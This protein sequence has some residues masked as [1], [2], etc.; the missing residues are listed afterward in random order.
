MDTTPCPSMFDWP[1]RMK[2]FTGLLFAWPAHAGPAS[3][4]MTITENIALQVTVL[5]SNLMATSLGWG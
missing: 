4:N 2:T 3:S 1:A 5:F